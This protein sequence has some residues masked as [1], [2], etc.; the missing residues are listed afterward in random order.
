MEQFSIVKQQFLE[1]GT[2]MCQAET[3]ENISHTKGKVG[4]TLRWRKGQLEDR[5]ANTLDYFF[6]LLRVRTSIISS[7][8][9][10]IPRFMTR[11]ATTI[12]NAFAQHA[13]MNGGSNYIWKRLVIH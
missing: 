6:C 10:A 1:K 3:L 4:W 5:S 8:V 12:N 11:K 13:T 9:G 2:H 7:V